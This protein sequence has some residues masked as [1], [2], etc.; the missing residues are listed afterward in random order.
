MKLELE[1]IVSDI[2]TSLGS[3]K[4]RYNRYRLILEDFRNH[5]NHHSIGGI[6]FFKDR[7]SKTTKLRVHERIQLL[8]DTNTPFFEFSALAAFD[9]YNNEFPSAGIVTGIGYINGREVIIVA[10]DP[11]VKGGTYVKETIKKHLRAQEI[12]IQ[13]HLPCVYMVDSGGIFLPDQAEV[14]PDKEG[15]GRIF[16]N[17]AQMSAKGIP[18]ISI[19]FGSST[20]GGAYIPAMS[21]ETIIVRNQGM[22]FLGGPPLVKAATGETVSGEELGGALVHSKISGVADYLAEDEIHAVKICRDIIKTIPPAAKQTLDIETPFDPAFDP[23]ELYGLLPLSVR[24]PVRAH[25]IIARI[26]DKSEFHEFK[27]EYGKT[28]ITGFARIMGFPVGIIANNG[29]LYSESALKATHFIQLC[30][31]RKVPMVFLQNISGF[32]VGQ[33]YENAGIAKEGAKMVH[34]VATSVV[35]KFTVVFGGSHGAGNYAMSGRAFDPNLLLMYPN[36]KI[37]VMGGEQAANVLATIKLEKSDKNQ[38]SSEIENLEILKQQIIQKYEQEGSAYYST[39]RLWD[40]GIIDPVDTRK[41]LAIGLSAS[42]NRLFNEPGNGI[43]RM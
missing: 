32:M 37:S 7:E 17:Q 26:V 1:K 35:P 4:E 20:A 18:Q 14:F 16:F 39:S 33:K 28:L 42:I 15:F 6:N 25:E 30:N 13:M 41:V 36:S 29:I 5:L 23:E 43:F 19:V 9:Q 40:D 27:R 8:I 31:F 22:I 10:N 24:E 38:G 21:D 2:N 3:F 34:A 12:A 11:S